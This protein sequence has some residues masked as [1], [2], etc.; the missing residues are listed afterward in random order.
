MSEQALFRL[1]DK[2]DIYFEDSLISKEYIVKKYAD[3]LAS[4]FSGEDHTVSVALHTGSIC[5]DIVSFII[6]A[7][8]CLS[9]GGSYSDEAIETIEKGD[10]VLYGEHKQERYIWAGFVDK[11]YKPTLIYSETSDNRYYAVLEQPTKA[12]RTYA[13]RTKWHLITPYNGN[14]QTTDGRGLRKRDSSRNDFISYVL[15]TSPE[16]V[17]SITDFSTVVVTERSTFERISKGVRIVYNE[18]KSIGL[19]DIVTASYY[20]SSGEEYQYGTNPAKSDPVLKIT[21]KV[22]TARDL[23]L[24]KRG[25]KTIGFI[26]IGSDHISNARTELPDLLDRK[27]LRFSHLVAG[28]DSDSTEGIIETHKNTAVFA[29]TKEFL[30]QNSLPPQIKNVLTAELDRQVEHI[31]NNNVA[32][33]IIDGGCSRDDFWNVKTALDIIRKSDWNAESKDTFLITAYSLLN[34]FTTA[35]FPMQALERAIE[36]GELAA[37]ICSPHARISKLW[38]LADDAGTIA[39]QCAYI[40]NILERLYQEAFSVCHKYDALKQRM[41]T[42]AERNIVVVVPKAYYINILLADGAFNLK[43]VTFSTT[44]RFD[45]SEQYDEVI[46]TGNYYSKRFNPFKCRA[47]ADITVLLYECELREFE[48][49]KRRSDNFEHKLNTKL[50]IVKDHTFD[51]VEDSVEDTV[52]SKD[53]NSFFDLDQYIHGISSIDLKTLTEKASGF[54]DSIPTTEV[55]AVGR[56]VNG[57]QIFFSK[58]YNAVVFNT[59]KGTV[60][61]IDVKN[62]AVGDMLVFVK[63]DDYTRNMVD[64]IYENLQSLGRFSKEVSVASEKAW[65]WKEAL[66]EYKNNHNLSYSDVAKQLQKLGSSLREATIRQWLIRESHTVGP[67]EKKTLEQI[68]DLIQDEFLLTDIHGYFESFRIVRHKRKEILDLIGRSITDNLN[69]HKPPKGSI[70]EMVHSNV[71]NLSETLELESVAILENSVLVPINV[72][73]KPFAE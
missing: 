3:F 1:L 5:F 67:R 13:P 61:E 59:G 58:Y 62:L 14:S 49:E 25:N 22:A 9:M 45:N 50:G 46:V 2:C 8:G 68:A 69:G 21:G 28:I 55:Y 10:I 56:F 51:Y 37:G 6:A 4:S 63:R 52:I 60:T 72:I 23:V 16:A 24:D 34:L 12:G 41:L 32:T 30:L 36:N 48:R 40:T 43:N 39:E 11:D 19:L 42:S 65:Y 38:D 18:G 66:R 57:E 53:M 29:C 64:Y 70:L 31:I 71:E 54:A 26:V 20:T 27:S 17:S 7:I 44:N 35:T 33:V 15:D 73:N 47:A